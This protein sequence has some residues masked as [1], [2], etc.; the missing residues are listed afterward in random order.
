MIDNLPTGHRRLL[1]HL[2]DP[3]CP[4]IR[5]FVQNFPRNV[6]EAQEEVRVRSPPSPSE[7]R[8][9]DCAKKIA[10]DTAAAKETPEN[11]GSGVGDGKKGTGGGCGAGEV[12]GATAEVHGDTAG[13]NGGLI[14][15][16]TTTATATATAITTATTAD[17]LREAYNGCL[18][19]LGDFR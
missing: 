11:G 16:G 18:S 10:A 14:A 5:R 13:G 19:A 3:A 7:D 8:G 15:Q 2:A 6:P 4:S 17:A 9:S 12:H 1:E